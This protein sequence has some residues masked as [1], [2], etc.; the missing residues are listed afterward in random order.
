MKKLMLILLILLSFNL[1]ANAQM[2]KDI[3]HDQKID[4]SKMD[5]EQKMSMMNMCQEM[6]QQKMDKAM[7]HMCPMCMHMMK[8]Q[9]EMMEMMA[10]MMKI[11]EKFIIGVNPSEKKKMIKKLKSMRERMKKRMEIGMEMNDSQTRL[12]CAEEWLKKA[13][14]L[15]EVHMK[16]PKTATEA[17]QM[18]MMEQMKKAYECLIGKDSK[19]DAPTLKEIKSKDPKKTEPSINLHKH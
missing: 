12:K 14:E 5:S 8:E 7:M 1:F 11:Q 16:D 10:E 15:H 17:S 4:Q 3:K 18:E 2:D 19:K 13:I 9:K 6:M